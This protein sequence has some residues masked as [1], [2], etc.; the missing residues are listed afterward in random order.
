MCLLCAAS[1]ED[2]NRAR[3]AHALQLLALVE[4]PDALPAGAALRLAREV[5]VLAEEEQTEFRC[6]PV[7]S[8]E[9]AIEAAR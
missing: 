1:S 6:D 3:R 9:P 7:L 4:D 2:R 8:P 5:L